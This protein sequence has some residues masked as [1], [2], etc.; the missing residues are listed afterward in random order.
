[1]PGAAIVGILH[2]RAAPRLPYGETTM[3]NPVLFWHRASPVL[4]S[5]LRIISAFLFMLHGS[6]KLFGLPGGGQLQWIEFDQLWSLAPGLAGV[7]EFFGGLLLLLGLATRPVAFVLSGLMAFAYFMA[8][9]PGS[10]WPVLNH[11]DAAIL[12]CFAFLYLSAAGGGPFSLDQLIASR[13]RAR[14]IA[15][16]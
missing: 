11:G 12:F 8:H 3:T 9:A 13:R 7:L 2:G 5:V 1:M 15:A 10:F 4:L 6:K 16:A 14:V